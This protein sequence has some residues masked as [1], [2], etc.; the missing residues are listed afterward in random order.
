MFLIFIHLIRFCVDNAGVFQRASHM[1][2]LVSTYSKHFD[3]VL[4]LENRVDCYVW[5]RRKIW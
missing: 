3:C 2:T 4:R 5:I 1:P